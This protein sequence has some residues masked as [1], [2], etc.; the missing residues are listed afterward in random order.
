[1]AFLLCCFILFLVMGMPIAFVIGISAL[2]YFFSTQY[3]PFEIATQMVVSQSQSFAFLAVP[4]FIFAG[5]LMNVSGITDRLLR[6]ARLLTRGMYGGT[7]QI[8]VVMSTLMGGVSGSATADA[9]METRILGPEMI[10]IGYK[11][12]YICAVNCV[13]ALITATIPPSLGLI[14]FG[15]VGEVSIG[16]LFAAGIIPGILMMVVLMA[17]T[18][19]TSRYYKYDPPSV[20]AKLSF[21]EVIDELIECVWALLFPILLIVGIR[22]GVF[23]PSESGA[24]AV[25]YAL[26][27]GKFIYKEL[28]WKNFKE[29]LMTTV[30]DNGAIM[31]IIA[32]SGPFSFAITW[33]K[34]PIALSSLI[35]G[36]TSNPQA[37]VLIMLG[38]LF[39]TGMFVDSNVNFLLLTPIF[40]PMV[41]SAGID[42]VHFGVLMATICTLGVMTPPIGS[43]LYTVCGIIDCP[44]EE[45][46]KASLPFMLAVLLELAVLVFLPDLVLFIPNLIFGK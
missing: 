28:N 26:I 34:L 6:L 38:F 39:I 22:M 7:A 43:A 44:P 36:I 3:L 21:K 8:S 45:Y 24:F 20:K 29:A 25:V 18:S 23:T 5:N 12:G 40:L 10:R 15:F 41:K 19:I 30:K 1:M 27:V 16:R 13:T 4:F 2:A 17:T 33:V 14:I 46:T 35:F 32:M 37:L 9:A 11:K 42:P 31:L